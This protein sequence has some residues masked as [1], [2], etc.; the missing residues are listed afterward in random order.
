M[1]RT[2]SVDSV[3]AQAALLPASEMLL[4]L[5]LSPSFSTLPFSEYLALWLVFHFRSQDLKL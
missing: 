2:C 3:H 1:L 5:F 4:S